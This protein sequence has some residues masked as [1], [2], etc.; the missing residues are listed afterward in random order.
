VAVKIIHEKNRIKRKDLLHEAK[1]QAQINLGCIPRVYDAF[2]WRQ[3]V[4]IVMEWVKGVP[5]SSLL[6]ASMTGEERFYLAGRFVEA[7]ASLHALGFAHRDLKP[8]NVLVTPECM[9]YLVDFGFT[10]NIT[11]GRASL[12]FIAKGTPAYMAPEVWEQGGDIDLVRADVYS[13]G[14]VL[15]EIIGKDTETGIVNK[16]LQAHPDNRLASGKEMLDAWNASPQTTRPAHECCPAAA[17][18]LASELL[19]GQ[20]VQAARQLLYA[21]RNDEAYWLLVEALE[22][23]PENS[24]AVQLMADFSR[25]ARK[26]RIGSGVRYAIGAAAVL[27]ISLTAFFIGKRSSADL[28][29]ITDLLRTPAGVQRIDGRPQKRTGRGDVLVAFKENDVTTEKLTGKVVMVDLP[30]NGSLYV[31]DR[32]VDG[33]ECA[34]SGIDLPYGRHVLTWRDKNGLTRWKERI[35]LLPF[36]TKIIPMTRIL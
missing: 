18:R 23:E 13:A 27:V 35:F 16:C 11:D 9:V 32:R 31:D 19:A 29:V 3:N 30:H 20:L 10:K 25:F 2:G 14:K 17:G 33:K 36:E 28:I 26:Q 7:V 1:V 21:R 8:A 5:L 22:E 6:T 34:L 4:C 24:D 15:L 12:A